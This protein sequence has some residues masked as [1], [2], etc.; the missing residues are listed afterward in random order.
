MITCKSPKKL[1]RMA[2]AVASCV[3]PRYSSRFSRK[4]FTLPQLFACLVVRQQMR[5]SYRRTEALLK[6]SPAWLAAIG[7]SRVPDHNTLSRAFGILTTSARCASLLDLLTRWLGTL[8]ALGV[9]LAI[10]STLYDTHHR[11]R[12]YEQRCRH[13]A[14]K[15]AKTA[16]KRRSNA[17]KKTPKLAIGAD[18]RSHLILAALPRTGMGSDCRDFAPLLKG[19]CRRRAIKRVLA[20]A[21]FDSHA[22]H[23]LARQS[24]VKALIKQ[25]AGRPGT[26]PPTSPHRRRMK[27]LL[28]GSQAGRPYGQRAQV[29]CVHSM[30]K[31][32]LGE[33][34]RAKTAEN[35]KQEM[36]LRVLTHN[37]MIL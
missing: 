12:H 11:S 17:A 32:N 35:R 10:D 18:T 28:A 21:G 27:R 22:N 23:E 30:M 20:D 36:L 15:Q 37:L 4:D 29:E 26:K 33:S 1:I 16:N 6:D 5:L 25:G 2:H 9:T 7:L 13:Y 24:G 14:S 8:K 34:L 3:L 19:V 31:R